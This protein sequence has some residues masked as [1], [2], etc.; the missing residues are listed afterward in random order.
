LQMNDAAIPFIDVVQNTK[1][2]LW[3]RSIGGT[4]MLIGHLIF[5]YQFFSIIKR[6]GPRRFAPA[7]F[8]E[9]APIEAVRIEERAAKAG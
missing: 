8:R 5:A 1:L 4:L 7:L 3:G 6:A 9:P 2:W